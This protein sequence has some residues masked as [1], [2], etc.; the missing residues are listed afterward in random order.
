MGE[1]R[2]ERQGGNLLQRKV[3]ERRGIGE[4]RGEKGKRQREIQIN[5]TDSHI[6]QTG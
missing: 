1:G 6:E 2:G 3:E 4:E 5:K